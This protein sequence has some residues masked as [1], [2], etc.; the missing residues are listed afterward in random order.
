MYSLYTSPH[1]HVQCVKLTS[2]FHP[3]KKTACKHILYYTL[4]FIFT[5]K[6]L[7]Y[8]RS[9]RVSAIETYISNFCKEFF[10]ISY[11]EILKEFAV[12]IYFIFN[13]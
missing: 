10:V 8:Y 9:T 1:N 2:Y 11:K 7:F 6:F 4:T 13:F 5:L 12:V 3:V